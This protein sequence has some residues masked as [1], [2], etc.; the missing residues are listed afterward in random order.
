MLKWHFLWESWWEI[1]LSLPPNI[2][3]FTSSFPI[4]HFL[5]K[6]PNPSHQIDALVTTT[7]IDIA[8]NLNPT[9]SS[10]ATNSSHFCWAAPYLCCVL[11][12][13]ASY[14]IIVIIV[15][16]QLWMLLIHLIKGNSTLTRP[17]FHIL[18]HVSNVNIFFFCLLKCVY[19]C[20]NCEYHVK[21]WM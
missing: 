9:K 8:P 21:Q 16:I 18:F 14:Q 19:Q 2:I 10:Q 7:K 20:I 6:E 17:Y 15:V 3:F 5:P 13:K 12:S 4:S 11:P 1:L